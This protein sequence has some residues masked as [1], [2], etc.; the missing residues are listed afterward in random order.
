MRITMSEVRKMFEVIA[1]HVESRG[2]DKF[3]LERDLYWSIPT[4]ERF[5]VQQVPEE[6]E[7]TIG[8]LSHDIER[9]KA[10]LDG[11][12]EP[13]GYAFVWLASLLRTIGE[14]TRG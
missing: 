5:E 9:L 8:Q 4:S 11:E 10:I 7:L 3:E 13:I 6:N 14:S 1:A 12:N 2:E